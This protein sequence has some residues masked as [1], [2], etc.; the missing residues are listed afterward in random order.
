M[1]FYFSFLS[2]IVLTASISSGY[3]SDKFTTKSCPTWHHVNSYGKCECG[4]RL[5]GEVICERNKRVLLNVQFCMTYSIDNVTVAGACPYSRQ[6]TMNSY[7]VLQPRDEKDLT[8]FT[9]GG[10]ERKGQLCSHCKDSLGVA[11]FSYSYP[12]TKCLGNFRGWLLY[13]A[14]TLVPI[15]VFF[16]IVVFCKIHATAAYMNALVCSIQ[17]LLYSINGHSIF[18]YRQSY[19]ARALLTIGGVWNLDFLRYIYPPFCISTSFSTLQVLA[20]EY[21]SAFYPL[22]LIVITYICIELYDSDYR[23]IVFLWKPF[24]LCLSC[25]QRCGCKI[26][27][28]KYSIIN[29]FASFFVFGYSKI[30]F[31]CYGFFSMTHM[32]RIDG[33][34][35]Q[36]SDSTIHY[37]LWHNASVPYLGL[38]HKPYFSLAM[39]VFIVFS[40]SPMVLL[41]VYPTVAFQKMFRYFPGVC[42]HFLYVFMDSFQ[43]CYKNGTNSTRDCRYFA[44]IYLLIR[45][46]Y[47]LPSIFNSRYIEFFFLTPLIA[48]LLFGVIRPYRKEI[49]N[50]LDC[51]YFGLLA[52]AQFLHASGEYVTHLPVFVIFCVLAIIP[53]VHIF[54]LFSYHIYLL[55]PCVKEKNMP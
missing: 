37:F 32:Y 35:V 54:L 29:A 18:I 19:L 27:D 7:Y 50:H 6:S 34:L 28:V 23:V 5:G 21:I 42:W 40:I 41:F 43:G 24:N 14:L 51:A 45:L 52:L 25:T 46:V 30:L 8:D 4:S 12:C 26:S 44:G 31:T 15:T 39:I 16:L 36:D 22:V 49:F 48:S 55:L 20:F 53:V 9:C 13:L 11:V 1:E 10:M 2:S 33:D 38:R 3:T 17:I 47:Y